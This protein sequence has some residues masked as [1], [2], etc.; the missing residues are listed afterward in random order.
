LFLVAEGKLKQMSRLVAGQDQLVRADGSA[1]PIIDLTGGAAVESLHR[2]AT[3]IGPATS[4]AGHL[5]V[6]NGVVCGDYALQLGNL[7]E[8]APDLLVAGHADLPEFGS[9]AY[10]SAAALSPKTSQSLTGDFADPWWLPQCLENIEKIPGAVMCPDQACLDSKTYL[11]AICNCQP[12]YQNGCVPPPGCCLSTPSTAVLVYGRDPGPCYCCCGM[13]DAAMAV[14]V[15]HTTFK[16]IHEFSVGDTVLV[17]TKPDLSAWEQV[18]VAF[19]SG[20]GPG[21]DSPTIQIRYGD[22]SHPDVII[23][24]SGQ[25]F[26]VVGGKLKQASRLVAGRDQLVGADG[27]AV[28][29]IDLIGGIAADTLHRIATSTGP[30]TSLAGHLM[31]ANGVMCGDYALQLGNLEEAAPNLLV[32]GHAGLPELGSAAYTQRYANPRRD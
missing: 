15:D 31:V 8:A 28:P 30:A 17:A 23:T 16:P 9:A 14:A 2:I 4:L 19:S 11:H 7:E 24:S 27:A 12:P 3:S 25:L 26:L 32:A 20:T 21:S 6:A 10:T 1:T 5:L 22:P 18:P 29:I 13:A